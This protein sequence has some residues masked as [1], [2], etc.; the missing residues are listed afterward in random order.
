MRKVTAIMSSLVT[1]FLMSVFFAYFAK[2]QLQFPIWEYI[3]VIAAIQ[4]TAYIATVVLGG[5]GAKGAILHGLL[6][7]ALTSALLVFVLKP[8]MSLDF[9]KAFVIITMIEFAGLGLG[10]LL[11]PRSSSMQRS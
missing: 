7:A 4:L 1:L 6:V 10:S 2:P 9:D 3:A 11:S 5:V 8:A